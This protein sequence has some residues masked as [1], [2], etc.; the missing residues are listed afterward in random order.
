MLAK[1]QGG[2][3]VIPIIFTFIILNSVSLF[4]ANS[5]YSYEDKLEAI[6]FV[7]QNMGSNSYTLEALGEC[8]RFEGYRYLFE[9]FIKTPDKSYMDSYFGWLYK[10]DEKSN[11]K[12]VLLS[13]I[14]PRDKPENISKWEKEKISLISENRIINESR[15]G[16]IHVLILEPIMHI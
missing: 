15:Y 12:V 14:D 7:R 6:N 3:I 1:K 8:P 13:L 16:R 9:Y 5:S 4:S 10:T 11:S 2:R